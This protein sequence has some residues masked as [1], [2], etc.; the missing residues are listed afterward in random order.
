[1]IWATLDRRPFLSG[2][3]AA[4]VCGYLSEYARQKGIYIKINYVNRDHVHALL[5]LPTHLCLEDTAHLLKGSSSHWINENGLVPGKFA[6]GRG[7]GV[8]SVSH[9]AVGEVASYIANQE[10]HHR[11]KSFAEEFELFLKRYELQW[12]KEAD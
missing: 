10:N 1:M 6:W 9:S 2:P 8:F 12:H 4:K 11:R 5:D 3:A 7:Y